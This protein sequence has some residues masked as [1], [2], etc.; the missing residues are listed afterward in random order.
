LIVKNFVLVATALTVF[1]VPALAALKP[2]AAAVDFTTQAVLGG[3]PFTFTLSKALARGPVVL[4]FYPKAFSSGCTVEAH[5]FAEATDDFNR[6]GASVVGIS[7]DNI[8]TL[9]KF[10]VEAC[11]NKFAV[12]VG[13]KA[14]I[15]AYDAKFPL[16]GVS[17]RTSYVIAP[18]GKIIF[19]HSALSVKGH[20]TG[21]MKAV[22][23]WRAAHPKG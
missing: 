15:K 2:G 21:T 14:I 23:D 3:K 4:F 9:T 1:A 10:S 11:R 6:L 20:V 7:A 12:A 5:E 18:G 13:S 17:N 22:Q 8:A 19:T 16:M